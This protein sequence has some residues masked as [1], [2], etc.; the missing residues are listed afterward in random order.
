MSPIDVAGE[1]SSAVPFEGLPIRANEKLLE[2]PSNVIPADWAP[3]D[4]LGVCHQGCGVIA[5]GGKFALEEKEQWSCILAVHIHPSPAAGIWAQS[6][7]QD[8]R[9]SGTA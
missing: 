3:D 6:L 1:E 5:G 9:T 7:C 2:I 8:G 4:T